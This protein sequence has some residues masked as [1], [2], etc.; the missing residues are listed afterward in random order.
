MYV[1]V[2]VLAFTPDNEIGLLLAW[3]ELMDRIDP[4]VVMGYN[5]LGFDMAYLHDRA[6][7]LLGV[8]ACRDRFMRFGRVPDRPS[9]FVEQKLASSA[10]GDNVLRYIDMQVRQRECHAMPSSDRDRDRLYTTSNCGQMVSETPELS[11]L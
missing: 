9:Q 5:V 6:K 11:S 8:E 4:D 1:H 7:E 2:Q 10:L 3:M